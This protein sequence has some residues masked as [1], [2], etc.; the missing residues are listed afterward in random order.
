MTDAKRQTIPNRFWSRIEGTPVEVYN[1]G[2][3]N[4]YVEV[5]ESTSR[6][7]E[8]RFHVAVH[9]DDGRVVHVAWPPL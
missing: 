4:A 8:Q 5:S 9:T 1:Q 2:S 6:D 7:G 3:G